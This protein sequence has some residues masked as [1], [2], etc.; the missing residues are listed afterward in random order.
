[1]PA[2]AV[3]PAPIAYINAAAV[4]GFVVECGVVNFSRS[5]CFVSQLCSRRDRC[6]AEI[7][8]TG[9]SKLFSEEL[10]IT[11]VMH[12]G[13]P[14]VITV[15][16]TAC[17]RQPL[18]LYG[19]A[20]N[21]KASTNRFDF[22]R[23]LRSIWIICGQSFLLPPG[24]WKFVEHGINGGCRGKTYL[25]VRGEILRPLGDELMRRH[26]PSIPSSIKN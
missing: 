25:S 16:K 26:F 13:P 19:K 18:R 4:K 2:P 5:A 17:S 7:S 11:R 14:V 12:A 23:F 3:I 20:W 8:F 6:L 10:N 1:M 9:V 24:D 15:K 21:D 22:C